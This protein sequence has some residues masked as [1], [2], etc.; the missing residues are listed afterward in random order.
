MIVLEFL[1]DYLETMDQGVVLGLHS[2]F[3]TLLWV[4]K[5]TDR[6]EAKR[7]HFLPRGLHELLGIIAQRDKLGRAVHAMMIASRE[8]QLG[9]SPYG[10][11]CRLYTE[12]ILGEACLLTTE[13]PHPFMDL[14]AG[15]EE[16]L[17][18]QFIAESEAAREAKSAAAS[19]C[20]K[21]ARR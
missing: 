11:V 20:K 7:W 4:I 1:S 9:D 5:N 16:K 2:N 19:G 6:A 3:E 10:K 21:G 12:R 15:D 17:L 8:G 14:A 13:A 18:A